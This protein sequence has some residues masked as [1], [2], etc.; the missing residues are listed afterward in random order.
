MNQRNYQRE[1]D[2][3]VRKNEASGLVPKLLLHVC[4]APCSSF[5]LESL[6][7]HFDVTVFF[8]NPNIDDP[9]EYHRRAEEEQRL[10]RE[11]DLPRPVGFLEGEYNPERFHEAVRGHERIRRAVSAAVSALSFAYARAPRLPRRA[12]LTILRPASRFL[13]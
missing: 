3:L 4:C 2:L 11:M 1:Q 12:V 10:L 6:A 7:P 9:E 13:R 5:C 8:C